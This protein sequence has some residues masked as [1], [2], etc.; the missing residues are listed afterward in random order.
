MQ[1]SSASPKTPYILWNPQIHY[2]IHNTLIPVPI[3]SH[4]NSVHGP[5]PTSWRSMSTLSSNLCQALSSGLFPPSFSTETLYALL[6]PHTRCT[7]PPFHSSWFDHPNT[8]WWAV[9]IIMQSSSLPCYLVPLNEQYR[10]LCSL[11]H[12]P[13]ILSHSMSS[14][15]HYAVFLTPLLPC[16]F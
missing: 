16:P 2:H 12:S 5:H 15:D 1:Q 3:I 4:I 6:S 11:P 13:V 10:S 8:I 14:T 9:Q 7:P